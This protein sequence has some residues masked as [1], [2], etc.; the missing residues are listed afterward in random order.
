VVAVYV[1]WVAEALDTRALTFTGWSVALSLSL[2]PL[3]VGQAL[4]SFRSL[5]LS[6][7]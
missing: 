3:V 2:V 5:A 7:R 4:K 1:P 6:R